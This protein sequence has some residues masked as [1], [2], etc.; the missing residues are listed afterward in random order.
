[1]DLAD[2]VALTVEDFCTLYSVRR[3]LAYNEMNAGRLP[4]KKAG[5]RTI[6]RK[7]DADKWLDSLPLGN[8]GTDSDFAAQIHVE[9]HPSSPPN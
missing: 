3:N 2:K 6:I 9:G 5:R 4:F 1:M 8:L 7:I